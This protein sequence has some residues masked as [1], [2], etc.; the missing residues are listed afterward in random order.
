VFSGKL[1]RLQTDIAQEEMYRFDGLE[2]LV[3]I[4]DEIVKRRGNAKG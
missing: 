2:G 4:V 3:A 1:P